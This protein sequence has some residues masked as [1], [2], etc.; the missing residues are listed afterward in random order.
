MLLWLNGVENH[1]G[2]PNENY[3]R[4]MME[5]FSL[6][7]DRGAYTEDDV[8]EQ[9][10]ALTG[11]TNDWHKS[12]GPVNFRFRKGLHDGGAEDHLRQARPLQLARL[13][14]GSASTTRSTPP[15]SSRSSGATS[16]RRRPTRTRSAR[17]SALYVSS[18]HEIKPVVSAILMHPQLYNGPRMVKSPIVYTAGLMR[19]IGRRVDT[20][21]YVWLER[22]RRP[23]PLRAAERRRLG[24]DAAG[25]TPRAS[26]AAG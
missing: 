12:K 9:A 18:K 3:A 19:R 11:W 17:S 6:G 25:S 15:S 5:L 1:A 26:A 7:A 14:A 22:A 4:E 2:A 13:R 16:S 8:R 10:R 24:R 21:D 20:I 23:A